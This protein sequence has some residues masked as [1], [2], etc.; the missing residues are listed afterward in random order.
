MHHPVIQSYYQELRRNSL[1]NTV[2]TLWANILPLY[3]L[4]TQGYGIEQMRA[5]PGVSKES[6][7][8][9]IR[10]IRNGQSKKICLIE[11]KR[12]EYEASSKNW[13]D[14]VDQLTG[15][16]LTMRAYNPNRTGTLHGIV[17]IGHY[18]R[19]YVLFSDETV[20]RDHSDT[21]RNIYHFK[22]EAAIDTIL[23][24]IVRETQ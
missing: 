6:A 14:A 8:I 4:L 15:Y 22:D 20:L 7:D 19:F 24:S 13:V 9:A 17:T 12:V 10:Y 5:A 3:F 11:E 21:D 1:E 18:S 23:R 2:D 16:M